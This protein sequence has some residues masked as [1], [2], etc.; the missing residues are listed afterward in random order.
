MYTDRSRGASTSGMQHKVGKWLSTEAEQQV[1]EWLGLFI[2]MLVESADILTVDE[3]KYVALAL[4]H[5]KL[6]NQTLCT[7]LQY[8]ELHTTHISLLEAKLAVAEGQ[9][10][11]KGRF[12]MH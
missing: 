6:Y 7:E 10:E 9:M 1:G 12:E 8:E 11:A 3:L 2:H 5:N 4:Q